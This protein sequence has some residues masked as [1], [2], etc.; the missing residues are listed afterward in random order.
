MIRDIH[1]QIAE[2][3]SHYN[4]AAHHQIQRYDVKRSQ[5]TVFS[6][7]NNRLTSDFLTA[8]M[9]PKDSGMTLSLGCKK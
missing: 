6:Q 7:W 3:M 1:P 2:E 4:K 9:K 5:R 8:S